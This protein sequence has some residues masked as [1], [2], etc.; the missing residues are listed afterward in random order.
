[1]RMKFGIAA[2]IL[3]SV[4]GIGSAIAQTK[5]IRVVHPPG[6]DL[7]PYFVAKKEGFF[8]KRG[9][10][11]ELT[12]MAVSSNVPAALASGSADIGVLTVATLLPA[13]ENGIDLVTIAGGTIANPQFPSSLMT[14]I[15]S[16]IK[17][18]KDIE[19]RKVG[20]PGIGAFLQVMFNEW[21][22]TKGIDPKKVVFVEVPFT[23]MQDVLQAGT[24]DAVIP[25][26]PF[27]TRISTA[28][29]GE[30]KFGYI[31][32]LTANKT[33]R[34]LVSSMTRD[35]ANKNAATIK[36]VREA[37][38][39]AVAFQ[40]KNPDKSKEAVGEFLKMPPQALAAVK[41]P[42]SPVTVTDADIADWVTILVK[43]KVMSKPVDP[44][45]FN[46]K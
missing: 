31:K 7:W 10:N 6:A 30:I 24:V 43:Q 44:A 19:G 41:L 39:E 11:V 37:L 45:K 22:A 32:E 29:V 35:Y 25:I 1:M 18:P 38:E 23:Q 15:D 17:E 40:A 20:I 14:K 34:I 8:E 28:K 2:A 27:I 4:I 36:S 16:P 13:I 12:T 5:P 33:Y 9:L 46:I 26:E 3:A 42:T 21:L